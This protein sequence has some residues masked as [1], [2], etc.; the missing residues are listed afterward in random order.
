MSE[1]DG[2]AVLYRTST[3]AAAGFVVYSRLDSQLA[4]AR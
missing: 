2:S 4:I 1:E 3:D